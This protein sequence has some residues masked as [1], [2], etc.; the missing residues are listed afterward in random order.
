[1]FREM[2]RKRQQLYDSDAAA[3]LEN[4]SFGVLALAGDEGYPYAV[5]VSY[6]YTGGT[7]YFHGAKTGHKFDAVQ[8]CS[9]ASFCVTA[10]DDVKPEKYTTFYKSAIAFGRISVISDPEEAQ[11]AIALLGRKYFPGGTEQQLSAE[12]DGSQNALCMMKL[13]IEHL[14]GKQAEELC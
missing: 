9:K 7:L 14:T 11:Q 5:P 8:R 13:E 3:I 2:R 1:M 4:G 6:V 12:I 10:K